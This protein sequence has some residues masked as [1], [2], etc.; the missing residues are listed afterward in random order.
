MSTI[1]P[2]FS[3]KPGLLTPV[4]AFGTGFTPWDIS[5]LF[6]V[7][8]SPMDQI[9]GSVH[10]YVTSGSINRTGSDADPI[11]TA[12]TDERS[13][14][15]K[16]S[17]RESAKRSRV[18]KQKHLEEMSI[19]LNQLNIENRELVNQ[20]G[21]ALYHCQRTKMEND[22]L[23]LE[24]RI[25]EEKLMNIRQILMFLQIEQSSNCAMWSYSYDNST[26][27]TVQQDPS[28]ITNHVIV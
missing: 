5:N 11:P 25:L 12:N 17:N 22:R 8:D 21:Y 24:H 27:V 3:S 10:E 16:L 26:V 6:S 23:R 20:L 4:P 9:P 14:K 7:F 1:S 2:V 18:K 19:Q 15:R 13:K 28:S